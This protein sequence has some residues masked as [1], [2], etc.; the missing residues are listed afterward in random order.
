MEYKDEVKPQKGVWKD[1]CCKPVKTSK[2]K[3]KI[4]CYPQ[5]CN[6]RDPL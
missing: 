5:G 4:C 2:V 1:R 6:F 3:P